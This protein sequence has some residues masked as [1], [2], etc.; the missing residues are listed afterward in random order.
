MKK[1][2]LLFVI[3]IIIFLSF[4]FIQTTKESTTNFLASVFFQKS[5]NTDKLVKK[6]SRTSVEKHKSSVKPTKILIVPGHDNINSGAMFGHIT[7]AEINLSVAKELYNL[8]N[9]EKGIDAFIIRDDNG[10]NPVFQKYLKNNEKD[11]IEFRS[12]RKNIMMDFIKAGKINSHVNVLHNSAPSRVVRILYGINKFANEYGFDITIH[13]HFNDYPGRRGNT[14][15]YSGFSIYV[16]EKQYSNAE[17]SF[18]LAYKIKE[19]L[20]LS[21]ASSDYGK[22]SEIVEDQ[23]LIAIGSFN[24]ADSVAVLIE[25]G[26]IYESYFTDKKIG[27]TIRNELARQT[28]NG[29]LNYLENEDTNKETYSVL[30]GYRWEN[31]L[32]KGDKGMGV[33]ALQDFLNDFGYYPNKGTL[34][35]CPINGN[36]GK[37]TKSALIKFQ[38]DNNLPATGFLGDM[39]LEVIGRKKELLQQ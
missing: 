30:S 2:S 10:Y 17:A 37:C 26:Y 19:Q 12:S 32:S 28:Y 13:I 3:S 33:L 36:F 6:F 16:P 8:L 29:V 5:V 39:T 11:I 31:T 15:K 18:D 20:K 22:E 21:F 25:Y 38:K 27:Q 35:S 1:L 23:D 4:N 24:T 7:E 14:G 9:K 34:N